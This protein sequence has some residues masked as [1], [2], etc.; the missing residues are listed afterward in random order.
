M[1]NEA[2]DE[3]SLGS[4]GSSP[5]LLLSGNDPRSVRVETSSRELEGRLATIFALANG[6]IG[7]RGTH[8]EMPTWASP[9]FYVAGT[10]SPGPR[11]KLVDFHPEYHILAHPLRARPDRRNRYNELVTMPNFP[12]PLCVRLSVGG[13]TVSLDE[14]VILSC[15]RVLRMDQARLCRRLVLR[16]R[17]G[18]RIVV[19]S[20]RFADWADT[21][22]LVWRYE[23]A[24]D[25]HDADISVLPFFECNVFNAFGCRMF[26][27]ERRQSDG[28][29]NVLCLRYGRPRRTMA[30][31]QAWTVTRSRRRI[32]MDVFV[33]VCDTA[34]EAV[35]VAGR[36][37]EAGYDS[38]LR[39][40]CLAVEQAARRV[41]AEVGCGFLARQGFRFGIQHLE[42][43]L[44]RD[45]TDVSVPIKGLTGEGY[46]FMVF[47]D[48]DFHMFPYYL[49][50]NPRQARNLLLYRHGILDAARR[51]AGKSGYRGAQV[52]WET[53]LTGDEETA[54]WLNLP[55][56]EIHISADVAMA[57]K[58]YVDWT[59]DTAFLLSHGAEIAFETARFYAS[60]VEW[61]P[62]L[63]EWEIRGVGCPDQYHTWADNN[64]FINRM[65]RWNLE[66]AVR[67]AHMP[68]LRPVLLRIGMTASEARRFASIAKALRTPSPGRDGV[69]EEFDGFFRLSTDIRGVSELYCAHAQ[70]VKQPDVLALYLPFRRELSRG[71]M[72]ANFRFYEPRTLHGSSLS[73]PGM[74]LA[75]ALAGLVDRAA[76]YFERG[77]RTDLDDLAG[78]TS[79]GVHL[80]GY[81]VLWSAL[82]F[83][84]G[85]LDLAGGGVRLAPALPQ[86]WSHASFAF[87]WRHNRALVRLAHDEIEIA[88]DDSNPGSI[89]VSICGA[90]RVALAP[91][92]SRRYALGRKV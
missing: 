34:D 30:M 75:A 66:W 8:E 77:T 78:N 38:R 85:G 87:N 42:M 50:T 43:A 88:A 20:E 76:D 13:R 1:R 5:D 25:G 86:T 2:A 41:G 36:A 79:L 11:E 33:A 71:T 58:R 24:A 3:L 82:V 15:E 10:Y 26:E 70:A 49:L 59:G 83:G 22:L 72:Q 46:R 31:A 51:N 12:Y 62:R 84:F 16:D 23:A 21:R 57:V 56:R 35:A 44:C 54:P 91:G 53:G 69:I 19:D 67:L 55:E 6:R 40:H 47:W 60:R 14:A 45:R 68:A 65:A 28:R 7:I 74:A 27:V 92:E 17:E 32:R 63:R 52:P 18:R 73:L 37:L 39:S 4:S 80:A 90:G 61:N 81:A 64:A 9:G 48:T 29:L 89:P